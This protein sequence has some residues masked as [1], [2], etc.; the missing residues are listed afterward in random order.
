M[1]RELAE[2][3][4][5]LGMSYKDIAAKYNVSLETV[6]S[7]K[8]RH[9][10][11]RDKPVKKSAPVA[12]QNNKKGCTPKKVG[13]K[14]SEPE[15]ELTEKQRLFCLYY[16]K[17]FNAAMAAIRAGYSKDTARSIGYNLLTKVYIRNE[18]NRLKLL[19]Q[20]SIMISEDD[21]VERYMRIAF[22]DMT[23]FAEFGVEQ[24]PAIDIAGNII[25]DANGEVVMSKQNYLDFKNHDQVDG[26][27]ICE[28]SLGKSGMK[29]KLED[30][31]KALDWLANY[32][33]MNPDHKHRKWH[34]Q[35]RLE[36]ERK[37]L[38]ILESKSGI[39]ED[40]IPDDGFLTALEGKAAAV[41][42]DTGDP[43]AG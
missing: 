29:V 25:I 26:G 15:P 35:E 28:I 7:W 37:K 22:A 30:R 40:D 16:V 6:K 38:D 32:F 19:K 13:A 23:D 21:I 39:I 3:D 24:S 31:Q 9:G 4:Y 14:E 1:S 11:E 27:L 20:Q 41:W 42:D 2:R 36:L 33:G 18:V 12:P 10:W 17:N 8:K 5:I 34:D 43:D